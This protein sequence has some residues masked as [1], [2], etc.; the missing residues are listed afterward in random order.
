M[1]KVSG[2]NPLETTNETILVFMSM[3]L[4]GVLVTA[5]IFLE[6]VGGH[7]ALGEVLGGDE[8]VLQVGDAVREGLGGEAL[9]V[10]AQLAHDEGDQAGGVG[11]VVDG[12]GGAQASGVVLAA[13]DARESVTGAEICGG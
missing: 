9:G 12:E 5:N 8:L 13:Q 2:S 7:G 11:G 3:R 4:L 1:G 6:R 10:D